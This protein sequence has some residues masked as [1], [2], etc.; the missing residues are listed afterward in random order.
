MGTRHRIINNATLRLTQVMKVV[1]AKLINFYARCMQ[2]ENHIGG[3]HE[4][5]HLDINSSR[6]LEDRSSICNS[7]SWPAEQGL[8]TEKRAPSLESWHEAEPK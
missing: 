4:F 5:F 2:I 3:R 7:R 1:P 6:G 8:E